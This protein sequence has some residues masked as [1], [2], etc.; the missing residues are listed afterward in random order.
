M[1]KREK[2]FSYLKRILMDIQIIL[3]TI[4]CVA[5]NFKTQIPQRKLC[6]NNC[7]AQYFLK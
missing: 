2:I 1:N 5:H 3:Y 6:G 4:F 7:N